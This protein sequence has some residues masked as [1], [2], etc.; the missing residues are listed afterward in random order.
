[1]GKKSSSK[2]SSTKKSSTKESSTK[3]DSIISKYMISNSFLVLPLVTYFIFNFFKENFFS[4]YSIH[5]IELFYM[6][7]TT[8]IVFYFSFN[9]FCES[10]FRSKLETSQHCLKYAL[11][12]VFISNLFTIINPCRQ[13]MTFMQLNLFHMLLMMVGF[14]LINYMVNKDNKTYCEISDSKVAVIFLLILN[15]G[16]TWISK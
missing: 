11:M 10:N 16:L 9:E 13:Y 14:N 6:T 2:K 1:M 4:G 5:F 15:G 7:I 8:T 12:L 3:S